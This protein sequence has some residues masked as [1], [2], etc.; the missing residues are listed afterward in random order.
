MK[1]KTY[2]ELLKDPRWQKKRLEIFSRDDWTCQ[3]C[4]EK[5]RTLTVHHVEYEKDTQPWDYPNEYFMT[6]CSDCNLYEK[7]HILDAK[8]T[9]TRAMSLSGFLADDF[10]NLAKQ[11][12]NG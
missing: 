9:C 7:D 5:S 10:Y 8:I 3:R 4:G 11:K 12:Y 6:L 1:K 2:V